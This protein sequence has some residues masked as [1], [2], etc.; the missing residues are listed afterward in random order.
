MKLG[1]VG[2]KDFWRVAGG[3]DRDE[4]WSDSVGDL[5]LEDVECCTHFVEFV[6]ADVGTMGEAEIYLLSS[7]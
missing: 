2:S 5:F 3:I 7:V 6:R 1:K 4:D